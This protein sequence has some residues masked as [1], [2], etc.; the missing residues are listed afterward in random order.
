MSS[1][2]SSLLLSGLCPHVELPKRV[3][4]QNSLGT[5]AMPP[6]GPFDPK[7][8]NEVL[9]LRAGCAKTEARHALRLLLR[10]RVEKPQKATKDR[11][12]HWARK[13]A[14]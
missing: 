2:F 8:K 9:P 5:L 6:T 11:W 10:T 1:Q 14:L 4:P 12:A 7:E 3:L 13:K